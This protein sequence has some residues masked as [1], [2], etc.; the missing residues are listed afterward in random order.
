MTAW[1]CGV[2]S[3]EMKK[4]K[5]QTGDIIMRLLSYIYTPLN[6]IT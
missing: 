2:S 6:S 5:I 4:Q 3:Y 1:N